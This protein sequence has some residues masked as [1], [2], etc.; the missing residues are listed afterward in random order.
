MNKLLSSPMLKK[1]NFTKP[2]VHINVSDFNIGSV[3]MQ[4]KHPIVFENNKLS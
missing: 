1:L 2:F 3:F 4:D